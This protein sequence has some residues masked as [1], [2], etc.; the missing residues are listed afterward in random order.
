MSKIKLIKLVDQIMGRT[1]TSLLRGKSY[2][3]EISLFN[4]ILLIRPG[5]IGDAVLLLPA[6]RA[7]KQAF[8]D[9]GIDILC[10]KRNA[11]IFRLSN[12]INTIYL[13]DRGI[14]LFRALRKKYD[15]VIDTEQWHRLSA[16]V[17]YLSGAPIRVGFD[18]NERRKL[19]T[20]R[21]PYSHDDYEV[22]SFFHLMGP[23]IPEAPH[24]DKNKPFMEIPDNASTIPSPEIE[25]KKNLVAVFPGASVPER[26]WGGDRFGKVAKALTDKGYEIVIL[27]SRSESRD[28]ERIK[29]YAKNAVDMTGRTDLADVAALLKS[30]KLL[31]SADSGLLHI[32]YA[33]GTPTV[34]L[35]GSG[36]ER[37]WAPP[38]RR[39]RV[40]NKR[41][42]CSPCTKFGYTPCCRR[43]VECMLS[44]DADEVIRSAVTLL[45]EPG[46]PLPQK[47]KEDVLTIAKKLLS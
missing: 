46:Q 39:H 30:C 24:F 29:E 38:G 19:F 35:F 41:L 31:V 2:V 14:D 37:K 4:K 1:F 11:D 43:N 36:I 8:P 42:P 16:V 17:A 21:I 25:E 23:L 7:L 26:Q 27:G 32:A 9:S 20:H 22:Y 45:E 44:I 10:E 5:G 3:S 13:Y 12:N 28:A 15:I 34:S 47:R 18:T 40:L 6:I 33:A